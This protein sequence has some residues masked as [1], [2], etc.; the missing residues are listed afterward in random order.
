MKNSSKEGKNCRIFFYLIKQQWYQFP[1]KISAMNTLPNKMINIDKYR[2]AANVAVYHI[3]SNI[4]FQQII[5]NYFM[6]K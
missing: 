2:V 4:I 6:L 1:S 5:H 3:V